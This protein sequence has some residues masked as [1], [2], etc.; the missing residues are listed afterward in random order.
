MGWKSHGFRFKSGRK[1]RKKIREKGIKISR[2]LQ[3]FEVGDRVHID[4]DPAVHKGMPHPRFQGRT[5]VVI[6]QRGRAYLV[7]VRD[8][9]SYKT[10]FVRPEHLKPQ[11][12]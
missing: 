10:L 1:L 8:G 7:R 11:K 12:S 5:G 9:N 3:T 6:G 2:A 4:I